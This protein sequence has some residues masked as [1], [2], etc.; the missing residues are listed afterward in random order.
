MCQDVMGWY[1]IFMVVVQSWFEIVVVYII[2]GDCNYI[3]CVQV[4]NLQYYLEFIIEWLYKMFGVM[5]ICLNIVLCIIKDC[6]GG[7]VLLMEVCG[8]CL[9]EGGVVGKCGRVKQML[10]L[11]FLMRINFL[12]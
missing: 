2:I 1:E 3:L 7:L 9:L 8:V 5:D 11:E 6:D 12:L 4:L 10:V